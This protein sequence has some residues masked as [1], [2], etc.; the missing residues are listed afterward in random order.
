MCGDARTNRLKRMQETG[1]RISSPYVDEKLCNRSKNCTYHWWW[2]AA[3]GR[4]C[5]PETSSASCDSPPCPCC[6]LSCP[7]RRG[8]RGFSFYSQQGG[9][10][11]SE[12]EE[13]ATTASQTTPGQG[14][15]SL[16]RFQLLDSW[17]LLTSPLV[18]TGR[19]LARCH[20]TGVSFNLHALHETGLSCPCAVPG[21]TGCLTS[22]ELRSTIDSRRY[23]CFC[24]CID[25]FFLTMVYIYTPS[26]SSIAFVLKRRRVA[27]IEFVSAIEASVGHDCPSSKRRG[28][29]S[30]SSRVAT[31]Y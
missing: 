18:F 7:C 29:G 14:A 13:T 22:A 2:W 21:T 12:A 31:Q 19:G 15:A 6:R 16:F 26:I 20:A 28:V 5:P 24:W 10:G 8:R 9:P 3:I 30:A 11:S 27:W 17:V 25:L 23:T 4:R 1:S